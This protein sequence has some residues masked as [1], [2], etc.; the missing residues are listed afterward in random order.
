MIKCS[1]DKR[2]ATL[3]FTAVV[4]KYYIKGNQITDCMREEGSS[5]G[6]IKADIKDFTSTFGG[7]YRAFPDEN[8]HIFDQVYEQVRSADVN[9]KEY[10]SGERGQEEI[11]VFEKNG[12]KVFKRV[13]HPGSGEKASGVDFALY[14]KVSQTKIGITAVQ[15]KRNRGKEYFEFDQRD[16]TQRNRLENLWGS[17]YYLMVDETVGPPPL[18]LFVSASDLSLIIEGIA[19]EPPVKIPNEYIRR[20]G[21]GL[22]LFYRSFY[23]GSMGSQAAPK[24]YLATIEMFTRRSKRTLVEISTR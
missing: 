20:H 1:L 12:V 7:F 17:A 9:Y 8:Q 14:K 16:L 10:L 24:D 5:E 23:G 18:Y 3:T 13:F 4:N 6:E 22:D 2:F 19:K 21:R 11:W 15:V